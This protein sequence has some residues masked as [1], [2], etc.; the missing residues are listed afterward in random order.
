MKRC[1]RIE[2][3][4]EKLS[5]EESAEY[6]MSRPVSS[7]VGAVVSPQSKPIPNRNIL[8]E[9]EREL[10]ALNEQQQAL[11][12]KPENW[13]GFA[14]IP[15]SVEFW[16]GQTNR[17]HDRIRFRKPKPGEIPDNII[18]HQGVNGWVYERLAP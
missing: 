1:V 7:R 10:T 16:Q 8:R 18:V 15:D 4:V 6:F 14:V 12:C 2:G 9:R 17:L 11:I 5:T 13:G 3:R